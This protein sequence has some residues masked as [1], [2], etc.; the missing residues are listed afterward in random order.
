[1]PTIRRTMR[2]MLALVAAVAMTACDASRDPRPAV[3]HTDPPSRETMVATLADAWVSD[4]QRGYFVDGAARWHSGAISLYRT[5]WNLR[6]AAASAPDVR[7]NGARV[8]AWLDP[9]FDGAASPTGLPELTVLEYAVDIAKLLGVP[10]DRAKV[11]AAVERLRL[12]PGYRAGAGAAPNW[13]STAT[14]VRIQRWL[15]ER[16]PGPVTAAAREALHRTDP[17]RLTPDLVVNDVV[18]QL[19]ILASEPSDEPDIDLTRHYVTVASQILDPAPID[20]VWLSAEVA[21]HSAA[22]SLGVSLPATRPAACD[23]LLGADGKVRFGGATRPDPQATYLAQQFGCH[24]VDARPD[25]EHGSIG[26]PDERVQAQALGSTVAAMRIAQHLGVEHQYLPQVMAT[27]RDRW[28]PQHNNSPQPN[29]VDVGRLREL[30][31]Y[32]TAH[33][34]ALS[35][36]DASGRQP[37]VA[38]NNAVAVVIRMW[39]LAADP[40]SPQRTAAVHSAIAALSPDRGASMIAAAS[41]ELAARL[42][43]DP[44]MHARAERIARRLRIATGIYRLADDGNRPDVGSLAASAIGAWIE[45]V[46]RPQ[47][48][49]VDAGFCNSHGCAE[50]ATD[51]AAGSTSLRSLAVF[52]ACAQAVCADRLPIPL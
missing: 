10:F 6:L 16:P 32:D 34:A 48:A 17:Q 28:L 19:E 30:M 8:A 39:A 2:G 22:K 15:G 5:R 33:M 51:L 45:A 38:S 26:W 37:S 50:S 20:A 29:P 43:A 14:V 44:T 52:H 49:W 25:P 27:V 18:P 12:G 31:S 4:G 3:E 41:F 11:I 13:G 21:L 1:M 24:N 9:A 46:P 47:Q 7:L 36:A 23:R 42:L 35:V 40:P